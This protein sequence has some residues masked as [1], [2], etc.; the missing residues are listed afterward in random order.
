MEVVKVV[1]ESLN[2]RLSNSMGRCSRCLI[3]CLTI[4]DADELGGELRVKLFHG[5]SS[6]E[7]QVLVYH[8]KRDSKLFESRCC[9]GGKR[10]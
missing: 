6:E 5:N 9:G 2:A 1:K 3:V 10:C 4:G 8:S 7:G